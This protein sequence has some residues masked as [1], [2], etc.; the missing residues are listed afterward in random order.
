MNSKLPISVFIIAKNEGDR[1]AQT[2]GSVVDW[3]DE[4]I[5]IDSGSTDDTIK[6]SEAA[7]ARVL[8][9]KWSGY[10]P[11]KRFGE[12]QC[13]ND[14]L[15]NLDADEVISAEL[16]TEIQNVFVFGLKANGYTMRVCNMLPGEETVPTH[17][18][19]NT[20]LRLYD[21]RKGRFS[22]S[23]VH[24]SVMLLEG[25]PEALKGPVYHKSFRSLE[26]AL[27][28]INYY[29]TMQADDMMARGKRVMGLRLAIEFPINFFKAYVFRRYMFRGTRGFN[30]AMIYAFSRFI[31]LAKLHEQQEKKP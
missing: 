14:W 17:T 1:I 18:Q 10:G 2:I 29:S 21:K 12:D 4:V 25:K 5:V 16:A 13:R 7:G 20:C 8:Y 30:Y 9:N 11:Q 24:D 23:P 6:A 26:H 27:G 31:R 3:V 28:K 22:D 15:L 19:I